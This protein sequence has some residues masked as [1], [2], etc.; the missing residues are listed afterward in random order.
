MV[1]ENLQIASILIGSLMIHAC[2]HTTEGPSPRS[3]YDLSGATELNKK[4]T[5]IRDSILPDPD[6]RESVYRYIVTTSLNEIQEASCMELTNMIRTEALTVQ[7][8]QD[9]SSL[10]NQHR[11]FIKK[12]IQKFDQCFVKLS[13]RVDR[14]LTGIATRTFVDQI[15]F[16]YQEFLILTVVAMNLDA[17]STSSSANY[18]SWLRDWYIYLSVEHFG[19]SLNW[20]EHPEEFTTAGPFGKKA[21]S[22]EE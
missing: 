9:L 2:T 19:R 5:L 10:V 18:R 14:H 20:I 6:S 22:F 21:G 1:L 3:A 17:F 16:F 7:S 11:D 13:Y 8:E 12:N 4:N 15:R